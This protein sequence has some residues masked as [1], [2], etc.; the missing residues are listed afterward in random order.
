MKLIPN[1]ITVSEQFALRG[2]IDRVI[3]NWLMDESTPFILHSNESVAELE[4]VSGIRCTYLGHRVI[5]GYEL[6][7]EEKYAWFLLKWSK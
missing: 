1:G 4:R 2:K 5:G 6:V 3:D 7:D